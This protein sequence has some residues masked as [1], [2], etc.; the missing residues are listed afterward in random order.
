MVVAKKQEKEAYEDESDGKSSIID[1]LRWSAESFRDRA[2]WLVRFLEMQKAAFVGDDEAMQIVGDLQ[3]QVERLKG[4]LSEYQY[5]L[6]ARRT[7]ANIPRMVDSDCC[8]GGKTL[9]SYKGDK[10]D[11]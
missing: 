3:Q 11:S 6:L 1:V 7:T 5:R 2:Y 4:R 9:C 8:C 10:D